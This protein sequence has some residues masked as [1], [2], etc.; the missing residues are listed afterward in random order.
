MNNPET[1][2][3]TKIHRQ[4][5]KYEPAIWIWKIKAG[6]NNGIPDALYIGATGIALWVEYKIHPNVPTALQLHTL[7]ALAMR[8]QKTAIITQHPNHTMILAP[9]NSVLITKTPWEWIA[10]QLGYNTHG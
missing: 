2:F 8:Q 9:N 7:E 10:T 5:K 3:I 4:L 6:F 1:A